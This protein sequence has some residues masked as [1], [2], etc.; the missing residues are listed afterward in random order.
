MLSSQELA[1][2]HL[3]QNDIAYQEVINAQNARAL[4]LTKEEYLRRKD[5]ADR[6]CGTLSINEKRAGVKA[7]PMETSSILNACKR[8]VVQAEPS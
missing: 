3:N 8:A 4:G 5:R 7:T 6:I 2:F 1:R